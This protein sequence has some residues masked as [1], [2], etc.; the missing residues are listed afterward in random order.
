MK[1]SSKTQS[2]NR[3]TEILDA[4]IRL[5][6]LENKEDFSIKGMMSLVEQENVL[7]Q[8]LFYNKISVTV[9]KSEN[10]NKVHKSLIKKAKKSIVG[11]LE[12]YEVTG[13][14]SDIS[15]STD[16]FKKTWSTVTIEH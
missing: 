10:G 2:T 3:L 1:N 12:Q 16:Q 11:M 7:V 13:D 8:F 5:E 15:N 9:L 6:E 4:M 14:L